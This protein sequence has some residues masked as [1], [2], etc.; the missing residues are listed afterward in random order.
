LQKEGGEF[1]ALSARFL[2]DLSRPINKELLALLAQ[3]SK[4]VVPK[5]SLLTRTIIP[6]NPAINIFLNMIKPPCL[7]D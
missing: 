4:K 1:P 6:I 2:P 5:L 3:L 7:K